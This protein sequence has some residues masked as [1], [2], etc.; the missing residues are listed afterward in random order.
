MGQDPL[1]CVTHLA[2]CHLWNEAYKPYKVYRLFNAMDFIKNQ[3]D[4]IIAV[5][6]V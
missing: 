5:D 6:L 3:G 4:I 2:H 1:T